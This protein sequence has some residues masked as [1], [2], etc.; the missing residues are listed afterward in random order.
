MHPYKLVTIAAKSHV[1]LLCF[2]LQSFSTFLGMGHCCWHLRMPRD[3]IAV[4]STDGGT[5]QKTMTHY[6]QRIRINW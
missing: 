5:E 4:Y 2:A 1:S 6:E 3:D